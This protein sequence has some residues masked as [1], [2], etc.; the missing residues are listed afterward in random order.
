MTQILVDE[1]WSIFNS[2]SDCTLTVVYTT[3]NTGLLSAKFYATPTNAYQQVD[4]IGLQMLGNN[5]YSFEVNYVIPSA[6]VKIAI[7]SNNEGWTG[8]STIYTIVINLFGYSR[9]FKPSFHNFFHIL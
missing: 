5:K 3:T 2:P 8:I 1:C 7:N 4:N 6:Y 9:L